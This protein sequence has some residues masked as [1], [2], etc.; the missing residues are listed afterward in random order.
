MSVKIASPGRA[1]QVR[2]SDDDALHAVRIGQLYPDLTEHNPNAARVTGAV[3]KAMQDVAN[4]D[5]ADVRCDQTT[6]YRQAQLAAE[7][8]LH[9]AELV[10][11]ALEGEL[12]RHV[13]LAGLRVLLEGLGY[14][15]QPVAAQ[16]VDERTAITSVVE[17]L[18]RVTSDAAVA[19]ADGRIDEA[20]AARLDPQMEE[21]K[22]RV[23]L[24][25]AARAARRNGAAAPAAGV[26]GGVR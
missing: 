4:G 17:Q 15:V 6:R 25:E 23:K 26:N 5:T 2:L 13:A 8:K 9:L 14:T 20:E 7:K 21:V 19:L 12:G 3:L 16:P 24:W 22:A 11:I 10:G 18:G 1:H